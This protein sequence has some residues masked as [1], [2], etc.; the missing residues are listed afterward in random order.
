MSVA[1]KGTIL[2]RRKGDPCTSSQESTEASSLSPTALFTKYRSVQEFLDYKRDDL[3][4]ALGPKASFTRRIDRQTIGKLV[5]PS[6]ESPRAEKLSEQAMKSTKGRRSRE[7]VAEGED[8]EAKNCLERYQFS[9]MTSENDFE[10]VKA[11]TEG[12]KG[13]LG[14]LATK[15][16][17][18]NRTEGQ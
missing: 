6:P 17:L 15:H 2:A 16:G 5:C 14:K 11:S 7:T 9:Q 10:A 13:K 12:M 4:F 8:N 18:Q 1:E 3:S